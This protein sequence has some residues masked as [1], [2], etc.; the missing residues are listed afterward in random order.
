MSWHFHVHL[1]VFIVLYVDASEAI[2]LVHRAVS[3]AVAV[4]FDLVHH[5]RIN[6]HVRINL[7]VSLSFNL[8]FVLVANL[9]VGVFKGLVEVLSNA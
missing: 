3:L 4:D 9:R 8:A 1:I 2:A 6:I 7:G 5:V